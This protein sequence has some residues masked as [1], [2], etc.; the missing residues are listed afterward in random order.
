MPAALILCTAVAPA[1]VE[2]PTTAIVGLF[3]V[4][5]WPA[6]AARAVAKSAFAMAK[7]AC[8]INGEC[9]VAT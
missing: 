4:V 3:E 5:A 2:V 6:C 7:V 8:A 9:Y 1:D